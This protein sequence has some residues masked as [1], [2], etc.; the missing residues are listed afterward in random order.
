MFLDGFSVSAGARTCQMRP[1]RGVVGV[2]K[3]SLTILVDGVLVF[4]GAGLRHAA[5]GVWARAVSRGAHFDHIHA[6]F[7]VLPAIAEMW[8]KMRSTPGAHT[9]SPAEICLEQGAE[10]LRAARQARMVYTGS[11]CCGPSAETEDLGRGVRLP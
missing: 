11:G 7:D 6:H 5:G 10:Q 2:S 8:V 9:I 3:P 1:C 4:R